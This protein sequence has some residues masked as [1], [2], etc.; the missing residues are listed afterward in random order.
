MQGAGFA[1]KRVEAG[2]LEFRV[3]GLWL[4]VKG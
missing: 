4:G 1:I 2:N 3:E